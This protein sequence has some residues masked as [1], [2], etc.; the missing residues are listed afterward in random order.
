MKKDN[1]VSSL[2]LGIISM[3]LVIAMS[4][5]LKTI[6]QTDITSLES[7]QE[8]E[9]R[10][11]I[12]DLKEKNQ[13]LKDKIEENEDKI[14]EYNQTI[15]NNEKTAELLAQELS[16]YETQ[17]GLTDV[18]GE[19]VIIT[20]T[21]SDTQSYSYSNLI[22]FVNELRYAG[23]TAISIND[24]RIIGS[25]EIVEIS[26]R[27]I[28]LNGDQRISSPYV[29]KAIGDKEKL[30]DTLTLKDEGYIDLYTNADFDVKIEESDS[31]TIN[32]YTKDI[33]FNYIKEKEGEDEK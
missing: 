9:L 30:M 32:K 13:D 5:Q 17:I 19:G 31:I 11:E 16:D 3:F 29:V 27:F 21:D 15:N 25:T 28:L 20:L 24:Y 6:D 12:L 22:D 14:D 33:N 26:K 18:T 1:I 10:N 7:M 8:E 23:A 4:I 2:V